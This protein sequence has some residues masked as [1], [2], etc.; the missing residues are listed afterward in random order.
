VTQKAWLPFKNRKLVFI[1][2]LVVG[3]Y[4]KHIIVLPVIVGW[5]RTKCVYVSVGVSA[6]TN[7]PKLT[8]GLIVS[9]RESVPAAS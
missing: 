2:F 5:E 9:S 3:I 4:I 7:T 8:P 6:K 1:S